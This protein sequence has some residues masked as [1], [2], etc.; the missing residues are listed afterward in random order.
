M[1]NESLSVEAADLY[2]Q[3]K[4]VADQYT[5]ATQ[6]HIDTG[7]EMTEAAR[8]LAEARFQHQQA[9]ERYLYRGGFFGRVQSLGDDKR[10]ALDRHIRAETAYYGARGS[11]EVAKREYDANMR[12]AIDLYS[13][14]SDAYHQ[15]TIEDAAAKGVT[16]NFTGTVAT[17]VCVL[18]PAS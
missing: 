1:N 15:M 7:H 17:N 11:E 9:T 12:K 10:W 2:A 16:I 8:E 3:H 4:Q 13:A 14:N 5:F 6:R 18:R